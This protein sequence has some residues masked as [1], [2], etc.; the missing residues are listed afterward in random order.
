TALGNEAMVAIDKAAQRLPPRQR[1][2]FALRHYQR[3]PFAEIAKL[4]D[5]TESGARAS[6]HKALLA[7]QESL[8]DLA[9]EIPRSGGMVYVGIREG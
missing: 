4:L 5:I 9:P 3:M 6:Y 8:S 2:I 1:A 7:L